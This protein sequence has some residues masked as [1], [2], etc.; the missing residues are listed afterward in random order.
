[1]TAI[2]QPMYSKVTRDGQVPGVLV[3]RAHRGPSLEDEQPHDE[4]GDDQD[5]GQDAGDQQERFHCWS[6][7][8]QNRWPRWRGGP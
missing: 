4:L 2:D 1:M 6:R 5:G 3:G 7:I 8:L